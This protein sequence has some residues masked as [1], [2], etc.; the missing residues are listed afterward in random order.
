MRADPDLQP[1]T[2]PIRVRTSR[3][4]TRNVAAIAL[5]SLFSDMS[6]EMVTS[7]LPL[8]IVSIGGTA[9]AVGLV[10]GASDFA[11]SL[12]KLGMSWY[13]DRIGR[14]KPIMVAGYLITALKG[15]M[16]FATT[17]SAV[18]AIRATAWLARGGRGPARDALLAESVAPEFRGRAFGL[19]SATDTI[20]A[21]LGPAIAAGLLALA[22]SYRHIFFVSLIPGAVT[23][24]I[25]LFVVKERRDKLRQSRNL[26]QSLRGLPP[27][28]WRYGLAVGVFGLGNFGHTLL[29]LHAQQL[30][31]PRFGVAKADSIA[32]GLYTLFN[33][34][35]A[36]GAFP[37]A[38]LAEHI[39]KRT[40]LGLGY[41][42]FGLMCAGFIWVGDDIAALAVLFAIGGLYIA[43]VDS[44]EAAQAADLLPADLIG[45]GYGTLGTFNGIGD[46]L[47]SLIVGL[48]WT[49]VSTASGFLYAIVLTLLGVVLLF[50]MKPSSPV[51]SSF[52][53]PL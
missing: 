46:L 49:H 29:I 20:G 48:L 26:L 38:L 23:V 4:L 11:A 18:I 33:A 45:T 42:L 7:V 53:E 1:A 41:L 35:Y 52:P 15:L 10:D 27:G 22:V 32:I 3:W 24:L 8:F 51:P 31:L 2:K 30:L 6:H 37:A 25:V 39:G 50:T 34:V 28:F 44:M 14:R 47:S 36:A 43:F 5:L 12:S 21:I 16:G 9:A 13:S 17:V 19:N 40:V